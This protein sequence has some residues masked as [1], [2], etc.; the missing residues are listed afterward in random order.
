MKI[1]NKNN[2]LKIGMMV[3]AIFFAIPSLAYLLE[4]KTVFDFNG[5]LEFCFLLTENISRTIQAVI[6]FIIVSL[7]IIFYLVVIK[8]RKALFKTEKSVYTFILLI[9]CIFIFVMP[10]WCSDIF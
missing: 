10:F 4:N 2:L 1:G 8:N 6:F 9:S 5:N 7:F 3:M